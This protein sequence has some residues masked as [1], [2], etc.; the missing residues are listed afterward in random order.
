VALEEFQEMAASKSTQH[1]FV[2]ALAPPAS[3]TT[4]PLVALG[5]V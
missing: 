3:Q 4:L 2:I 5:M 1:V